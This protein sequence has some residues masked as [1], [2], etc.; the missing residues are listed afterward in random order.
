[1]AGS[2]HHILVVPWSL[3]VNNREEFW[4]VCLGRYGVLD[5]D[6]IGSPPTG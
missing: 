2:V 3:T 6:A 5:K 4:G 1:M